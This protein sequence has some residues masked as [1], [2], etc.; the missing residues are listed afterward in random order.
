MK[1]RDISGRMKNMQFVEE[2]STKNHKII[3]IHLL[4]RGFFSKVKTSV[5][6]LEQQKR[7]HK[8]QTPYSSG[9]SL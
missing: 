3:V 2:S 5:L 1:K 7:S 8:N 4:K 9:S 6:H